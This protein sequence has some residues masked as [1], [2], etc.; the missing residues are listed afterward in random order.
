[1]RKSPTGK[2]LEKFQKSAIDLEAQISDRGDS[3]GEGY[4]YQGSL[5]KVP[6]K[7][8]NCHTDFSI[9]PS[10][11]K[12]GVGCARAC[13]RKPSL[14]KQQR[15]ESKLLEELRRRGDTLA[16]TSKFVR[17]EH[18]VDIVCGCC[19][20][21]F[22]IAPTKY[23]YGQGCDPCSRSAS[24]K[25]VIEE[26]Q[27]KF[28]QLVLDRGDS[29]AESYSYKNS[30]VAVDLLCGSG[31]HVFSIIPAS[32]VLGG[33]CRK[34]GCNAQ[35]EA[36]REMSA[37]GMDA[38]IA[39][40]GDSKAPGY[41]YIKASLPVDLVCGQCRHPFK[42]RPNSYKKGGGCPRCAGRSPE[43]ARQDFE[44]AIKRRGDACL[45]EYHY[46][47]QKVDIRC[48]KCTN[49][50]HQSPNMYK[51]GHG[52]PCCAG[53]GFDPAKPGVLYYLAFE[54]ANGRT[55]YKIGITNRTVER[56]YAKCKTPYRVVKEE[57][58]L[59]G[60]LCKDAERRII[61]KYKKHRCKDAPVDTIG[62]T[63]LFEFDVLG[64]DRGINAR[65]VARLSVA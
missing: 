65:Y 39:K 51:K 60:H 37:I 4:S 7:C 62:N 49:V 9:L 52:C 43:K 11:Y 48:G 20:E 57:Y 31:G 17:V 15:S 28:E 16:P 21:T 56:R 24:A 54:L 3:L 12:K 34:H 42:K 1:M 44:S 6:I 25:R 40:R 36:R 47:D 29:K 18:K 13:C 35:G 2:I 5:V 41:T 64:I 27:I 23:N 53:S 32:Y 46:N 45:S 63:E 50:Y 38:E 14:A 10:N 61:K 55:V 26:W 33:S 22:S 30:R 59:F 8:G 58:F 19:N